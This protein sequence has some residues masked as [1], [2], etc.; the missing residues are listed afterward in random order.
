MVSEGVGHRTGHIYDKAKAARAFIWGGAP[1][2]GFG[3][4]G[5]G[6]RVDSG[7]ALGEAGGR[8]SGAAGHGGELCGRA[9][10]VP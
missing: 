5:N 8:E 1:E 9:F 2:G 6:G 4:D 3:A 10:C 7:S